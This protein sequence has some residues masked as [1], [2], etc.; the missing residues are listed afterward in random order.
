V[1]ET[2]HAS[3]VAWRGRGLLILGAPG[4]GK[5]GLALSLMALGC[6][7]VADD[8]VAVRRVGRALVAAPPP[9]LAGLIEARGIG[10]LRAPFRPRAALTLALDLD[11]RETSRLPPRR[12]WALHGLDLPLILRP[13][14]LNPAAALAA[15]KH[16]PPLY[17]D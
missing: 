16:G 14:P 8:R 7:L 9:A 3:C 12:T 2:L 13:E 15:L 4:A 11:R 1:T 17:P 5:S 6:A 10:L